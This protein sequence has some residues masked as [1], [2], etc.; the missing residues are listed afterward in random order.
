MIDTHCHLTDPRLRQQ[1]DA[2]RSHAIEAGVDRMITIGTSIDDSHA[3]ASLAGDFC[4]VFAAA[5][6]HPNYCA[7]ESIDRLPEL[8]ALLA[9]PRVVALGECG[10]DYHHADSPRDRQRAFFAAQLQ[11]ADELRVPV[12]VHCRE[13]V[14]DT[15]GV[16][17]DFT[18]VRCVF[19]CFTGT[20]DEA[21]RVLDAGHLI[22]LTGV[23]TF[24]NGV[25]L[26]E[27]AR[28][29]P[30][31]FLLVETDAPYLTPEPHR[32]QKINEPSMTIHT[33]ARIAAE[34]GVGF[35]AIDRITT[36]NAERFFRLTP[37]S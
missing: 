2:V 29:V 17:R 16:L 11:I 23:V 18:R 21:R 24:K 4:N 14:D 20:P 27:V 15:L 19:H 30:D 3:A 26:R 5:G 36:L 34:R 10:L 32:A 22:G 35:D 7:D 8:R 12:I 28:L 33:A 25:A 31:D 6:V 9:R 37:T 13:A 1:L